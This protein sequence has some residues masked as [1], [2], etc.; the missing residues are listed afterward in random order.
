MFDDARCPVCSK[1]YHSNK[2]RLLE[3]LGLNPDLDPTENEINKAFRERS[4]FAHPDKPTGSHELFEEIL[5]AKEE[6]L[7]MIGAKPSKEDFQVNSHSHQEVNQEVPPKEE[8]YQFTFKEKQKLKK[9]LRNLRL[10]LKR[11]MPCPF[12][13]QR[14]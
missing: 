13:K 14:Y 9:S 5:D 10:G 8:P 11:G 12:C 1:D 7:E 3:S 4:K 6:L 2:K